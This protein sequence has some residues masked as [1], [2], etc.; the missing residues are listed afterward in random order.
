MVAA[1]QLLYKRD[2]EGERKREGKATLQ[3]KV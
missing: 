2:I 1:V 3:M